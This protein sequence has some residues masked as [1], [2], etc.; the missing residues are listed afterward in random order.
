MTRNGQL[1][2]V[3]FIINDYLRYPQ[4]IGDCTSGGPPV[5]PIQLRGVSFVPFPF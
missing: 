1:T 4:F 2:R 3:A 5:Q